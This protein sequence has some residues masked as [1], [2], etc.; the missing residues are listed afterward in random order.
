MCPNGEISPNLVTLPGCSNEA[1][2]QC[3]QI[4]R[5]CATGA[6]GRQMSYFQTEN[7]DLGKNMEG[8]A[9]EDVST[10]IYY[11]MAFWPAWANACHFGEFLLSTFCLL[12]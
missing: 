12:L 7:P 4:G 5:I 2:E 3:D 1:D 9:M 10:F 6:A 8:L 11:Y